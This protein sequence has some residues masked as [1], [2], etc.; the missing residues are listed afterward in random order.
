MLRELLLG[1]D[2]RL[3][4]VGP[5]PPLRDPAAEL[6]D[7]LDLA[8][9]DD[10]VD[11]AASSASACSA[12]LTAVS[13]STWSSR[14]EVDAAAA[15]STFA[16]PVVGQVHGAAVVV[17]LV[18]VV[19]A[20]TADDLGDRDRRVLLVDRRAGQDQ[21]D[22]GLVDQDRVGLVDDDGAELRGAPGRRCRSR[23]VAEQVEAGLAD[24]D[25]RDVA[26]HTPRGAPR[27]SRTR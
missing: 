26:A 9:A 18:V 19:A 11:V 16:R 22:P 7:Q 8:V 25:I 15:P 10:V 24:R 3:Q 20:Q 27:G 13:E 21:R 14:V 5:A 1:L 6:V 12:R 4:A 2:R 23:A 17:D